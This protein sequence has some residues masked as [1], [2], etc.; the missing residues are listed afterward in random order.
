M[1]SYISKKQSR[2]ATVFMVMFFAALGIC[3]LWL[4]SKIGGMYWD[5][6][7]LQKSL[8]QVAADP[9]ANKRTAQETFNAIQK[10]IEVQNIKISAEDFEMDATRSPKI[11]K[12]YFKKEA[13]LTDFL[14]VTGES[15]LV[16]P[17]KATAVE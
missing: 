1:N 10:R 15:W 4:G 2:G 5:K 7:L 9:S 16:A 6:Y 3:S 14:T 17:I 12:V 11:I 8:Q 13:Q